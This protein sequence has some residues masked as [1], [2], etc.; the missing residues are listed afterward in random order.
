MF[1]LL[2][3]MMASMT[4][5]EFVKSLMI[6]NS[7]DDLPLHSRVHLFSQIYDTTEFDITKNSKNQLH[8]KCWCNNEHFD[9]RPISILKNFNLEN[10]AAFI[11]PNGKLRPIGKNICEN[12][13]VVII[14][15]ENNYPVALMITQFTNLH[16]LDCSLV[17]GKISDL[18]AAYVRKKIDKYMEIE[19]SLTLTS[20][21]HFGFNL[22]KR[23]HEILKMMSDGLEAR[24]IANRLNFSVSTI[25]QELRIIYK[26]LNV[27]NRYDAVDR[28]LKN[29][30]PTK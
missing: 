28:Y 12:S 25:N 2:K 14:S 19:N 27:R 13:N 1:N 29:F 7:L 24:E 16:D 26:F 6:E 21:N 5:E 8:E 4:P 22:T 10:T 20:I 30:N 3:S 23:Q 9:N 18:L 17:L 15:Q 11:S